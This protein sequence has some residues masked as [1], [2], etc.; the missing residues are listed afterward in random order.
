MTF[1][2]YFRQQIERI[3]K[4]LGATVHEIHVEPKPFVVTQAAE[5]YAELCALGAA[6]HPTSSSFADAARQ[7][8]GIRKVPA[9]PHGAFKIVVDG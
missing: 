6:C 9:V 7:G 4:P 3:F 5:D 2:E 8:E 1:E